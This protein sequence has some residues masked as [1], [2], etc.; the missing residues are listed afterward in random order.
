MRRILTGLLLSAA[1]CG[2]TS[3]QS[4]YDRQQ[5]KQCRDLPNTQDQ[6]DCL[7]AA[8]DTGLERRSA[9]RSHPAD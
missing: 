5:V 4:A 6:R 2:C 1:L 3:L 7:R 8:H 9:T